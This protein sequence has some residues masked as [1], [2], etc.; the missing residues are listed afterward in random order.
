MTT[1][2]MWRR[3]FKS[4]RC[5]MK[6][7]NDGHSPA[8]AATIFFTG[9][10]TIIAV[11]GLALFAPI[12]IAAEDAAEQF[13]PLV[14]SVGNISLPKNF[15]T[16]F[17]H[18]GTIAVASEN[19]E[20]VDQ[21][22]STYTRRQDVKAFQKNGRF[23]DGAVLVKEVRGAS[24]EDLTTGHT[25]YASEMK[26][27][28]VMI[29]DEKQR[30]KDNDLWGSG[31]GWAMFEGADPTKQVATDYSSDCLDCHIPAEKNDWVFTQ[32]YPLLKKKEALK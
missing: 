9:R 31:W 18:L 23:S 7:T 29:K 22:H 20:T 24:H 26:V 19:D 25:S 11:L 6:L 5:I 28:F 3:P 14:D 8:S 2:A 21:M 1:M 15:N 16:E 30:F 13:S 32:C 4:H 27:W 17:V 12:L 10:N